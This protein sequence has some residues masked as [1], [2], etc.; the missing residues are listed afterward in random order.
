MC[1]QLPVAVFGAQPFILAHNHLR[2]VAGQDGP[3]GEMAIRLARE[4]LRLP[5]RVADGIQK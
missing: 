5:V 3:K 2:S 4:L 1:Q